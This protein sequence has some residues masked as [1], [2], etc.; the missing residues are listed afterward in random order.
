MARN[1]TCLSAEDLIED[2]GQKAREASSVLSHIEP[3]VIN[4][5]L[6]DL[7]DL[8]RYE[9]D[10]I[11]LANRQD[12]SG[13]RAKKLTPSMIDRLTLTPER[14]EAMAAGVEKIIDLSSP[15]GRVLAEWERPNGLRIQKISVP[16][17]VLG[18]IYE[19]RP[20]VTIDAAALSLKSHNAIILRGGS[21]SLNSSLAIHDLIVKALKKNDLPEGCVCMVPTIDRTVVTA[22]LQA[23]SSID[24]LIPRGGRGLTEKVMREALMPVFAHLDGICHTY[25][26]KSADPAIA[27]NVT[28]NAKMRRTGI[29]GATETLLFDEELDSELKQQ[30]LE[31]LLKS[32]CRIVATP[33]ICK[34]DNRIGKADE[35]DW[36]TE[37][38][39]AKLS[40]CS[41]K[42][43]KEAVQHIN[44]YGSH[45]TD[46]IIAEDE[47][48]VNWFLENVDS[49]IVMHN[50]STQF[51][52]G[53]EF[54]MGAEMGI[55]TGKLHARG[56]VGI[57][58]LTTYK[59]LVRGN[60]Q[61]R[62]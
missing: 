10:N 4:K 14:I 32:D 26:D 20:N 48:A 7:A 40:V 60:G 9:S 15:S 31:N 39:D 62:P 22:M 46:A 56:P 24:V 54:G 28:L 18:M 25:V 16:L 42:G 51:A 47:K 13:S 27:V 61:L 58:Q 45:H 17:G 30:I 1:Q 34:L 36:T 11:I 19:S 50:T 37:Y 23:V 21:E 53:G 38:L 43:V 52:D 57:E 33:D 49:G 44:K 59:Y 12:I 8:L 3:E 5:V 41:V 2:L 55:S 29:C 6:A 35:T